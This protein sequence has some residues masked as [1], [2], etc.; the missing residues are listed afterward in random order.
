MKIGTRLFIS[1]SDGALSSRHAVV[2]FRQGSPLIIADGHLFLSPQRLF[3]EPA[4]MELFESGEVVSARFQK[5]PVKVRLVNTTEP[6]FLDSR[7]LHKK[8]NPYGR[9][10]VYRFE[11][12]P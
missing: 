5:K 2:G 10:Q 11:T 9:G 4:Q 1:F 7:T 6:S 3:V 12:T 8:P